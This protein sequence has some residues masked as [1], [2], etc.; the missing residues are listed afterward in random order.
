M[1]TMDISPVDVVLTFQLRLLPN[2]PRCLT[3]KVLIY[4]NK[5]ELT[6]FISNY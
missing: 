6:F 3:I 4:K 2:N 5:I 1:N